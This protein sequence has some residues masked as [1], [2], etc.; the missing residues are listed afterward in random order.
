LVDGYGV[1]VEAAGARESGVVVGGLRCQHVCLAG[2]G[3][4]LV[5]QE[6]DM[7]R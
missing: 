1:H 2:R 5:S 3:G 6:P 4:L 7:G